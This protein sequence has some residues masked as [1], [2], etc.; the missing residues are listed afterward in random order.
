M[1]KI[2]KLRDNGPLLIGE[3]LKREV[4]TKV[5][6][7]IQNEETKEFQ[8]TGVID[9]VDHYG[10]FDIPAE[11]LL[12]TATPTKN[13]EDAYNRFFEEVIPPTT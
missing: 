13:L 9:I 3:L 7:I 11:S 1:L 10:E 2:I 8:L 12:F 6:T 4:Y 5:A